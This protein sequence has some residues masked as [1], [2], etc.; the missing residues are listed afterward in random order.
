MRV[1]IVSCLS[2]T[3]WS[4]SLSVSAGE[5][6]PVVVGEVEE[7]LSGCSVTSFLPSCSWFWVWVKSW[8]LTQA[9]IETWSNCGLENF[10]H[11]VLFVIK[12]MKLTRTTA[13]ATTLGSV[14]HPPVLLYIC[15]S[16][17]YS[18]T[19]IRRP[20]ANSYRRC[21]SSVDL[22][23]LTPCFSSPLC[24]RPCWGLCI[25][26]VLSVR[27]FRSEQQL[28]LCRVN[29]REFNLLGGKS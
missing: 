8:D 5:P 12:V 3:S 13:L 7:P 26:E 28:S 4:D 19:S 2:L 21:F 22:L 25:C 1:S 23:W 15:T 27:C 20:G 24:G 16:P 10:R 9:H 18:C 14:Q 29:N 17:V 6:T 11:L